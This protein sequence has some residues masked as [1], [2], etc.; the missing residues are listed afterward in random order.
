MNES[1]MMIPECHRRL[2]KAHGELKA[3]IESEKAD[4][5]ETEEFAE[6]EKILALADEQLKAT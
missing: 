5:G 1:L 6:A 3:M 2:E 4:F